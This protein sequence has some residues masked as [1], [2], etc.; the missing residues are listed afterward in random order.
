MPRGG[1]IP[2]KNDHRHCRPVLLALLAARTESYTPTAIV[3]IMALVERVITSDTAGFVIQAS[4]I[5][6]GFVPGVNMT[7]ITDTLKRLQTAV[8]NAKTRRVCP[9]A[10]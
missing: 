8:G 10:I 3:D 5:G 2:Y 9:I 7:G 6:L 1:G 4:T